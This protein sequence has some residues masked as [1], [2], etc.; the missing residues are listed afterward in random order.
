[1][2]MYNFTSNLVYAL[3]YTHSLT[4]DAEKTW[5][6]YF[7]NLQHIKLHETNVD[8]SVRN[9]KTKG[10]V[11]S[12]SCFRINVFFNMLCRNPQRN[13]DRYLQ[14]LMSV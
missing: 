3:A 4:L 7:I 8:K 14:F 9:T 1:M 2:Y 13:E 5:S 10:K 11:R 12:K 6:E